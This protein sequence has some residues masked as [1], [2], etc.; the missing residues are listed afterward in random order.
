M[1]R[2]AKWQ[3]RCDCCGKFVIP[4]QPGSSWVNVPHSDVSYG[5]ERERCATCT[6]KHG[7]AD[8]QPG[9]VKHLVQGVVPA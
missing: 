8:A 3:H 9:Y 7:P 2:W 1:N 6:A 5:D 4:G